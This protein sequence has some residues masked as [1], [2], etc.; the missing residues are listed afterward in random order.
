MPDADTDSEHVVHETRVRY[1]R[2]HAEWRPECLCGWVGL[3]WKQGI[4]AAT[5]AITHKETA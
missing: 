3:R 4:D 5:E 1:Q 2:L